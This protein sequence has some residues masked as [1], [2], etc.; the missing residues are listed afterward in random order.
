[1]SH[2]FVKDSLRASVE[3]ATGGRQTVL[4]TA[5]GQPSYM[6]VMNAFNCEDV[7]A[8]VGTGVHPMFLVDGVYKKERFIGAYGGVVR[9]GEL[10]S[11][12]HQDPANS[13]NFD[14]FVSIARSN[15]AGW[16]ITTNIDRAGIAL[17]CNK[18]GFTPTG[19]TDYGRDFASKHETGVRVDDLLPGVRSGTARTLTGSGPATWRHDGTFS[20]M[21][22]LCGN[23]WEWCAGLRLF[24]W[25]IQI[26]P[27]NDASSTVDLSAAS[28]MW[29]SINGATG[30]L[31]AAGH[32]NAV[33]L[34]PSGA[35]PY[36]LVTVSGQPFEKMTNPSTTPVGAEALKVLKLHGVFPV[37]TDLG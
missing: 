31:V 14:Q 35:E 28:S 26:I 29:R 21:S 36:T 22:D 20:G 10:I 6:Y 13:L 16:G 11:L 12:P 24:N 30:E 4:Y 19:N 33:K 25:E 7:D 1:M 37:A 9:N 23:M 8:G 15:G 27:D 18:N 32:A 34:K 3:A 5:K 2:I 17:W